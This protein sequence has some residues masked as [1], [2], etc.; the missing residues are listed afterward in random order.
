MSLVVVR[1]EFR[2]EIR[3]LESA[4]PNV[5]IEKEYD[6]IA[7]CLIAFACRLAF[8]LGFGGFVSLVPKTEL[9]RHYMTKYHLF[10]MGKHLATD[11]ENSVNLIAAYLE[12][13]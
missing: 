4:K 9:I 7:G 3:L 13:D 12:N 6:R 1:S 10:Q 2:V 5:G 8:K 11:G